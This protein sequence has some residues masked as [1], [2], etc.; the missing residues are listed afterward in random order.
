M[1]NEARIALTRLLEWLKQEQ[2]CVSGSFNPYAYNESSEKYYDGRY[3]AYQVVIEEIE[4][5]LKQ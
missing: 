5:L 1:N 3:D 2:D 4:S